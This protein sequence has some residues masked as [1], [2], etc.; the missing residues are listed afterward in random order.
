MNS[1]TPA[2]DGGQSAFELSG[3]FDPE[4]L[5]FKS[6][7]FSIVLSSFLMFSPLPAFQILSTL[8]P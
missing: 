2:M 5:H 3:P 7:S 4:G 6:S 8:C 1:L